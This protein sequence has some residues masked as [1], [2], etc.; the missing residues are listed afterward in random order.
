[1]RTVGPALLHVLDYEPMRRTGVKHRRLLESIHDAV[2]VALGSRA[3]V[4][5]GSPGVIELDERQAPGP[6]IPSRL[7]GAA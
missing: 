6:T 4:P 1:M 2:T 7:L 3:S 5:I